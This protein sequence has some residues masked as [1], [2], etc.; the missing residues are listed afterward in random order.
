ME[1]D[2]TKVATDVAQ[3]LEVDKG[4]LKQ[5]KEHATV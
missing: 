1:D 2:E 3:W 5:M 4:R